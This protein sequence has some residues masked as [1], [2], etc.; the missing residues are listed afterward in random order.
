MVNRPRPNVPEQVNSRTLKIV[1]VGTTFVLQHEGTLITTPGGHVVA[2]GDRRLL[3]QIVREVSAV[4]AL[5]RDSVNTYSI[6]ATQKDVV[7]EGG[8]PIADALTDV[9]DEDPL[10][11]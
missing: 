6:F 3:Q 11:L 5:K 10:L 2:N 4:G 7:E 8:D 9:L 1:K